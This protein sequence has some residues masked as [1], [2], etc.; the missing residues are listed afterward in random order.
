MYVFF[1]V[2]VHIVKKKILGTHLVNLKNFYGLLKI[3][4][5]WKRK[6]NQYLIYNGKH[7][8]ES[9]CVDTKIY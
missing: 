3:G 8:E 1:K 5:F 7:V 2:K 9:F 6:I 4:Y